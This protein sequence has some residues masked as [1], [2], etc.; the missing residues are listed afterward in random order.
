MLLNSEL[1]RDIHHKVTI[2]ILVIS[3]TNTLGNIA[4]SHKLSDLQSENEIS[5]SG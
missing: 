1:S 3:N 4:Q 2:I 5:E